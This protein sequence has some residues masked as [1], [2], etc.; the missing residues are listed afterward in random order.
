MTTKY[1]PKARFEIDVFEVPLRKTA[2]GMLFYVIPEVE[3]LGKPSVAEVQK[4]LG[5]EVLYG[6]DR[7]ETL[8]DD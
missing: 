5:A 1:D 4:W 8:V 6:K 3:S 2:K 7:L